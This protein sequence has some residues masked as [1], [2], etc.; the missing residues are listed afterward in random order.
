MHAVTSFGKVLL[1]A[2]MSR[3]LAFRRPSRSA[4]IVFRITFGYA[5]GPRQFLVVLHFCRSGQRCSP[6]ISSDERPVQLNACPHP[7]LKGRCSEPRTRQHFQTLCCWRLFLLASAPGALSGASRVRIASSHDFSTAER[8][9]HALPEMHHLKSN[10]TMLFSACV[11]AS[12]SAFNC[13][14][15]RMDFRRW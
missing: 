14:N 10:S 15:C 5:A 4:C 11:K 8:R 3:I 12:A 13:K 6:C 1:E 2:R 9:L 7:P